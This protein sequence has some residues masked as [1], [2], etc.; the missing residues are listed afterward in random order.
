MK[1]MAACAAAFVMVVVFASCSGSETMDF[2]PVAPIT[3]TVIKPVT[4]QNYINN[5]SWFVDNSV[6]INGAVALTYDVLNKYPTIKMAADQQGMPS[7][8]D[9]RDTQ[10]TWSDSQITTSS[11]E[12][13]PND[14]LQIG[15]SIVPLYNEFSAERLHEKVMKINGVY[16]M[17][18][19]FNCNNRGIVNFSRKMNRPY[20]QV[21]ESVRVDTITK[22]EKEIEIQFVE[23]EVHDTVTIEKEILKET[24]IQGAE[25]N[26]SISNNWGYS[27]ATMTL[28]ENMLLNLTIK[29]S[30]NPLKVAVYGANLTSG[31]VAEEWY[32]NDDQ[33]HCLWN[34][35]M[36]V[37]NDDNTTVMTKA[38]GY[39]YDVDALARA[40]GA[41]YQPIVLSEANIFMPYPEADVIQ[42]PYFNDDAQ[43]YDF[44][45]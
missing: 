15:A 38:D 19:W 13:F 10:W 39:T 25:V 1:K 18:G 43:E 3:N 4:V 28:G 22:T 31:A 8:T 14:T 34:D 37:S 12:I 5:Y 6:Y 21:D 9:E 32:F 11:V 27:I 42:N 16:Q 26:T 41:D 33:G 7:M 44:E 2:D 30:Y 17:T 23:V 20:Y 45:N 40:K 35:R 29:H 36:T 24:F